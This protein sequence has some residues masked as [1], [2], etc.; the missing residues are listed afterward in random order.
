MSTPT[1][2]SREQ[3]HR[4]NLQTRQA[5]VR[6]LESLPKEKLLKASHQDLVTEA[7]T[8]AFCPGFIY[9]V[10][11]IGPILRGLFGVNKRVPKAAPSDEQQTIASILDRLARVEGAVAEIKA[12]IP[13]QGT[14][15]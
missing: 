7:N 4:L 8:A 13:E 6:W 14:L 5:L 2:A 9:N 12:R 3:P 11:H 1:T 15:L 10:N